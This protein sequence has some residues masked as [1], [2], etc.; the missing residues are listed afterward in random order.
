MAL[1][2]GI[3]PGRNG[4]LVVFDSKARNGVQDLSYAI[5]HFKN[6]K[7]DHSR[8]FSILKEW[9]SSGVKLVTLEHQQ[10]FGR[11]GRVSCFSHGFGFGSLQACLVCAGFSPSERPSMGKK[12]SF[13]IVLPNEWKRLLELPS[14]PKHMNSKEKKKAAKEYAVELAMEMF[15]TFDL[16]K[17]KRGRVPSP[18]KSEALLLATCGHILTKGE[19]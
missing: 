3:D 1:Y 9:N 15:P 5:P 11:E 7:V 14:V 17:S 8:L 13:W 2:G 16:R 12:P 6:N 18:D 10:P 19:A 4:W